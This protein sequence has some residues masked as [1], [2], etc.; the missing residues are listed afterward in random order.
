MRLSETRRSR[1]KKEFADDVGG[2]CKS[3]PFGAPVCD[4]ARGGDADRLLRSPRPVAD[5]SMRVIRAAV[6]A[7]RLLD[8]AALT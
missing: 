1:L 2:D 5:R 8:R 4:D 7:H 6:R 3:Y